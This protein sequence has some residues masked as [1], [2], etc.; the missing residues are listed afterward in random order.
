MWGGGDCGKGEESPSAY[1]D[2]A[3]AG[4]ATDA[5]CGGGGEGREAGEGLSAVCPA[6][7][8]EKFCFQQCRTEFNN[9]I[10]HCLMLQNSNQFS[11]PYFCLGI[12]R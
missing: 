2:N 8:D 9:L 12:L 7:F 6:G 11:S 5:R 10:V 1:P 4:G 3:A